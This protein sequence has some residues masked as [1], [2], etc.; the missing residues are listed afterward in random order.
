MIHIWMK[1]YLVSASNY[2]NVDYNAQSLL[3]GM[4]NDVEFTFS[5]SDISN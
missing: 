4:Q 2:N 5:V 3:Q 1:N